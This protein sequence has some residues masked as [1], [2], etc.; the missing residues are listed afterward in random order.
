MKRAGFTLLELLVALVVFGLLLAGLSRTL[1]FG[2]TAWQQ[3][4]RLSAAHSDLEAADRALRLVV[5][6]LTPDKNMDAPTMTGSSDRLI[7][8]GRLRTPDSDSAPIPAEVGLA[9][10][11]DR[12]VLR[13]RPYHHGIPV[14]PPPPPREVTLARHVIRLSIAYWGAT[15]VWLS[16][17]DQSSLPLLIRFRIGLTGA[18]GSDHWPD[19]IIATRLSSSLDID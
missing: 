4:T 5:E 8:Q 12:L 6:N 9:L 17:W 1:S 14:R 16:H 15:G 11:G 7:G 18:P 3:D 10:S 19:I 2:L 13:W